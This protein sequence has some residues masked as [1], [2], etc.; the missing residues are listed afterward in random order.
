MQHIVKAL[1][2]YQGTTDE[3]LSFKQGEE[4][5]VINDEN[6]DWWFVSTLDKKSQ[7][8]IPSTFVRWLHNAPDDYIPEDVAEESEQQY[9]ETGAESYTNENEEKE[10]EEEDEDEYYNDEQSD[11]VNGALNG[12]EE[13]P[14]DDLINVIKEQKL[15]QLRRRSS[16]RQPKGVKLMQPD[17]VKELEFLPKGFRS[18]T[19]AKNAENG[20]F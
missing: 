20:K 16:V 19:L 8:Y 2:D 7:G 4:F 11:N 10:E 17:S 18:S 9:E 1:Y 12:T 15:A 3:E 5:R 14:P 13:I 6:E